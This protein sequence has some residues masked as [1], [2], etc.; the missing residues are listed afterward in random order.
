MSQR[1][2]RDFKR[3]RNIFGEVILAAGL[4]FSIEHVKLCVPATICSCSTTSCT[5]TALQLLNIVALV[6]FILL[7]S[8]EFSPL[9]SAVRPL[10]DIHLCIE[11]LFI[12]YNVLFNQI[13]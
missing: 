13:K 7:I 8:N 9:C 6:L 1:E 11:D 5:F 2:D 4:G 3:V 10:G 12:Y